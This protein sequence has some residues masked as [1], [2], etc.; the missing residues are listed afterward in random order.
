M[1]RPQNIKRNEWG[2]LLVKKCDRIPLMLEG[3]G[4]RMYDSGEDKDYLF[5]LE[6]AC[7]G[8]VTIKD[9]EFSSYKR[10]PDC[11]GEVHKKEEKVEQIAPRPVG[12]PRKTGVSVTIQLSWP[13]AM[14]LIQ[15]T[16]SQELD[17]AVREALEQWLKEPGQ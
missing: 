14:K 15:L 9:S 2:K 10:M 13:T 17:E 11:G 8:T 4:G 5:T 6:C 1:L 3:L 16:Q 12:R 7:G